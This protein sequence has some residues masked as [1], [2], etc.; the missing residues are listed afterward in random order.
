MT[1]GEQEEAEPSARSH[2]AR[3]LVSAAGLGRP[4]HPSGRSLTVLRRTLLTALYVASRAAVTY[5]R[6][7]SRIPLRFLRSTVLVPRLHVAAFLMYM[8][9][10]GL[11]GVADHSGI[12]LRLLG[13]ASDAHD[14]HHSAGHGAGVYVNL[15][16]PFVWTDVLCGTYLPPSDA[17]SAVA[18]RAARARTPLAW[19]RPPPPLLRL[20]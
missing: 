10:C 18:V 13:Y 7:S 2:T 1:Q 11:L 16:F 8:A 4:L 20:K 6:R 12:S 9:L 3:A 5:V 15:A 14:A 19:L 17:C